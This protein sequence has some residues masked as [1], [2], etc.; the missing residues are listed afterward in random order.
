M[1]IE[2]STNV[3]NAQNILDIN[4][5]M[6]ESFGDMIV[7]DDQLLMPLV[8]SANIACGFHGGDPMVIERTVDM[9]L[10]HQVRI[11][12]HPSYPDRENFGRVF[13]NME[14]TA[15]KSTIKYQIGAMQGLV[16][17]K[18][19]HLAYVKPHGA[20]YNHAAKEE[21]V[22][23]AVLEAVSE[24][25]DQLS[26]MGLSG[27]V[28]ASLSKEYKIGFIR[29]TFLDRRYQDDGSL[30]SRGESGAVIEDP[31]QA[32]E[33]LMLLLTQR[34]VRTKEGGVVKVEADTYC[35]HGDNPKAHEILV[36]IHR[37]MSLHGI[38]IK[39]WK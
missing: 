32:V 21:S 16:H 36:A 10:T 24:M 37:W 38:E 4:S 6:G 22:A 28:I 3:Q 17:S 8:S 5:D 9:A 30:V 15:L 35:I 14:T 18:G 23:H 13:M 2:P 20:L 33:Q 26:I 34:L 25:D 12:A 39:K 19:G 1:T 31:M 29:E 11:G 27:S 7:G